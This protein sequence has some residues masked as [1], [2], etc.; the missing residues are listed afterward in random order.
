[1]FQSL[2][3]MTDFLGKQTTNTDI[4]SDKNPIQV[5]NLGRILRMLSKSHF[6]K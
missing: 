6:L 5:N 2:N 3:K 4:R 1:M